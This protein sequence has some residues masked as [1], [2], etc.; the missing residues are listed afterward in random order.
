MA[1]LVRARRPDEKELVRFGPQ[2]PLRPRGGYGFSNDWTS[3]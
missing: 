3:K 1:V 2:L